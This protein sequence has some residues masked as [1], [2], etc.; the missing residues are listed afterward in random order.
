MTRTDYIVV[1]ADLTGATI[2]RVLHDAG[3]EII[4]IERRGAVG[5]NIVDHI[6]PDTGLWVHDHGPHLFRTSSEKIW[7][8]VQRFGQFLEY[9]HRVV[10]QIDGTLYPWPLGSSSIETIAGQD[11]RSQLLSIE[12]PSNLEEAA[13][14]LMPRTVYELFIKEYNEKQWGVRASSLDASLCRRFDVREDDDPYFSP[15]ARF[16]GLPVDGYSRLVERMLDGIPVALGVDWLED[17]ASYAARRR[18][19]FT[20]P[21]DLYYDFRFGRLRYRC[22]R[23]ESFKTRE[24]LPAPVVNNPLHRGGPYIRTIDWSSLRAHA[25]GGEWTVWTREFP[26]EAAGIDEYEYPFPSEEQFQLYQR[27]VALKTD[28]VIFCG[29]LGEYRYLDMDQAIG[30]AME[31]ARREI[32]T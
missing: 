32:A 23:R 15:R 3:R 9:R 8:F 30:R 13:L 31:L 24:R 11:W 26:G 18:L 4:V 5:G 19:F 21:I 16:Q 29:R 10:S 6:D 27:Y 20:G 22:Q 28:E 17:R 2:A 14:S 12:D 1:G 7:S 25:Y